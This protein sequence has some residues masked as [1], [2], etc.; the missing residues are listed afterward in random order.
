MCCVLRIRGKASELAEV[1]Q[2]EKL[3][4]LRAHVVREPIKSEYIL[5]ELQPFLCHIST[6]CLETPIKPENP[7]SSPSTL[8]LTS[9]PSTLNQTRKPDILT[10]NPQPLQILVPTPL[11]PQRATR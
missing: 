8:N 11:N 4:Q 1:I 3:A 5:L 9:S 10:L 7:T 6:S 2:A